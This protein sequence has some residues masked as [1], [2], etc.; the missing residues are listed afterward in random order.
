MDGRWFPVS[1]GLLTFNHYQRLGS[2]VF[3]FLWFVHEERAPKNGAADTGAVRNG[4]LITYSQISAALEGIPIRTVERHVALLE[5]EG[6]IRSETVGKKGKRYWVA[7]PIRWSLLSAKIDHHK[8]GGS[9]D[10]DTT[11]VADHPEND[12]TK[13]WGA[14]PQQC[15]VDTHKNVVSNKEQK[16]RTN[17]NLK[18]RG[19]GTQ[20]P[21][22]VGGEPLPEW[23][24]LESWAGFLEMRVRMKHP[25]E[26]RAH[27][28]ALKTLTDLRRKGHD[29]GE[30]LDQ[31]VLNNWRGLFPLK[32]ENTNGKQKRTSEQDLEANFD[33]IRQHPERFGQIN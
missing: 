30:V 13:M 31:S 11:K 10:V 24:P 22:P 15:G 4:D 23:M 6:Y 1:A 3:L 14:S 21:L 2:A 20:T 9:S 16:P 7:N 28:L 32:G 29:P 18:P 5:R 12:T 17:K 33:Y 27:T 25:L 8:N 26:G 19:G